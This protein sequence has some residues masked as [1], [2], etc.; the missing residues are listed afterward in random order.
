MKVYCPV[1]TGSTDIKNPPFILML[2]PFP[3]AHNSI[4]WK[5]INAHDRYEIIIKRTCEPHRHITHNVRNDY[6]D[7]LPLTS[8]GNI[9]KSTSYSEN[10]LCKDFN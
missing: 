6:Y 8:K 3:Q 10:V 1:H 4:Q 9:W 2:Y 5:K 7:V